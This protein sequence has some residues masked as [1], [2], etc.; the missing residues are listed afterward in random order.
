M[1]VRPCSLD[2][3]ALVAG[4]LFCANDLQTLAHLIEG[5]GLRLCFRGPLV[6][7]TRWSL[8]LRPRL[9]ALR[10]RRRELAAQR[11]N[12]SPSASPRA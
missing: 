8:E 4:L 11:T 7:I 1:R 3:S 12:D 6:P 10:G 2:A 9:S 5:Y